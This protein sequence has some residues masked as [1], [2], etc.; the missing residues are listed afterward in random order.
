MPAPLK[1]DLLKAFRT[2][3]LAAGPDK[4]CKRD[5]N[6]VIVPNELQPALEDMLAALAEGLAFQWNVWQTTQA[7]TGSASGVTSGPSSAP[8]VGILP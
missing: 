8:V 7:V 5:E 3:F 1:V 2:A 6:G 4:F